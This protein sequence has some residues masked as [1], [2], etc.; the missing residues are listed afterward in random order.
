MSGTQVSTDRPMDSFTHTHFGIVVQLDHLAELPTL[1]APADL[2]RKTASQTLSFFKNSIY[3]HHAAEERALFPATI[4]SAE[5]GAEKQRVESM[6]R[7]LI[8]QHRVL[9]SLWEKIE[10][11][12]KH[13]AKGTL[14][15]LDQDALSQLVNLY[16]EHAR[17]EECEFLP[18]A[19][20][21]LGRN[22]N[23]MEALGLSMNM[24]HPPYINGY[25]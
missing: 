17:M 25:I 7:L 23:H 18:L 5:E 6:V 2:A 12:L 19:K 8:T 10:P 16:K 14:H 4:K 15:K 11:E 24:L 22:K 1:L 13:I 9:E 3:E 20:E 21:I